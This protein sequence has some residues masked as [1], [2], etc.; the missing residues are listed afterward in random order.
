MDKPF[1]PDDWEPTRPY[2]QGETRL[3]RDTVGALVDLMNRE[4]DTIQRH[5]Y[6]PSSWLRRS[7]TLA[8][9]RYPELAAGD[10]HKASLLCRKMMSNLT[11]QRRGWRVGHRMGFWMR[12]EEEEG[13]EEEEEEEGCA[14]SSDMDLEHERQREYL[15]ALQ[16]QAEKL[17]EG[18]VYLYPEEDEGLCVLRPY[19]WLR[20]EH[21]YRSDELVDSLNRDLLDPNSTNGGKSCCVL[22]RYA[23]GKGVGAREG[24]DLLGVFA[25]RD[26]SRDEVIVVDKSRVW[27]CNGPGK[28][29][30][31]RNLFG[32]VACMDPGHPNT[33]GESVQQDLRWIRDRCGRRAVEAIVKVRFLM[34]AIEDGVHHPL[35]H[36]L[37]A[38]LTP[39]YRKDKFRHFS[40][41]RDIAVPNE[42]LQQFGIDI[43]ANLNWDTWTIFVLMARVENNSWGDPHTAGVNPLFS[44]FNHSCEPNVK[45]R[46]PEDHRT[47]TMSTLREVQKGEQLFVT[48]NGF[49]ADQPLPVRRKTF[50]RWLDGPCQCSRC[51]RE[52][53]EAKDRDGWSPE[54]SFSSSGSGDWVSG[55]M[56]G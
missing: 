27:G 29:G 18:N 24:A 16:Q 1:H 53:N 37:I 47:M 7:R 46:I 45:W 38:A 52:Q 54:W 49:M 28:Q 34:C 56:P 12:G 22:K 44:M 15:M 5:P 20:E 6:D 50:W 13:E 41:D 36:H 17:L 9:L 4:T 33:E 35:D 26:I 30:D 43:F 42:A 39:T 40:L 14:S 31:L 10:A 48:Y 2:E 19:P 25:S 55:E 3:D 32:G 23:F 8:S 21:T 11:P 51:L